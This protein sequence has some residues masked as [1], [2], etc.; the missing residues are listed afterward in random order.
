MQ[1]V[2]NFERKDPFPQW[3]HPN[4]GD[5]LVADGKEYLIITFNLKNHGNN[6]TAIYACTSPKN[7]HRHAI[8]TYDMT[9]HK[10]IECTNYLLL[11]EFSD[12]FTAISHSTEGT[13]A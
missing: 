8:I 9:E 13:F 3:Q 4:P 2:I 5:I 1:R 10:V 12:A 6:T 7:G 11:S